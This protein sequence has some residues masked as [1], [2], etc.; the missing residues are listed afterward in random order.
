MY[1]DPYWFGVYSAVST[2][3]I[4]LLVLAIWKGGRRR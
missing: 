3:A 1:V 2:G 4:L